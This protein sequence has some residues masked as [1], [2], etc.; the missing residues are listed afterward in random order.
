MRGP[1]ELAA[2]IELSGT[3]RAGQHPR[4]LFTPAELA[5]Q[6]QYALE[7]LEQIVARRT[8]PLLST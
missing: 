4:D 5:Q 6:T 2:G 7:A 3:A 1:G 8:T